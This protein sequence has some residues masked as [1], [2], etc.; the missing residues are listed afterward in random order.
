LWRCLGHALALSW[1][2]LMHLFA[3]APGHALCPGHQRLRLSGGGS[4]SLSSG[5]DAGV[6]IDQGRCGA[7]DLRRTS[8]S[9]A[10]T[11]GGLTSPA[12]A[13]SAAQAGLR[14]SGSSHDA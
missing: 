6:S 2:R 9:C 4:H 14:G 12:S 5:F 1:R 3:F 13:V 8:S 11:P 7:H 10:V